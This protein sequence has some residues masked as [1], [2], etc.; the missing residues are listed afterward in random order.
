MSTVR[1]VLKR[2]S[3]D[4]DN[5]VWVDGVRLTG[6]EEVAVHGEVGQVPRVLVKLVPSYIEVELEDPDLKKV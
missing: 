5:G 2:S 3:A 1:I 4:P 6:I